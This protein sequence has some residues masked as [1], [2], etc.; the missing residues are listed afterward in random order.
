MAVAVGASRPRP[1]ARWIALAAA[2]VAAALG[3]LA[4]L[5]PVAALGAVLALLF[6]AIAF[7]DLA[8]GVAIYATVMFFET[9]PVATTAGLGAAK[10]GGLVLVL[11][12]LRRSGTPL[13][14]REHPLIAYAATFLAAWALASSLWAEDVPLAATEGSRLALNVALLFV[15]FAAVRQARHARWV[16]WGYLLGAAASALVGLVQ[17]AEGDAD[18]LAG[19]V[20]DPNFLAAMLVPAIVFAV[21]AFGWARRPAERWLLSLL[22]VVYTIALLGTQSRG[23]LVAL[24]VTL[25]AGMLLGGAFRRHFAVLTAAIAFAGLV[26]YGAFASA[27]ALERVTNPGGGAGRADLWSVAT[28]VAGDHPVVGVGAGNFPVVAPQYVTEPLDLREVQLVVDEPTVAH[29]TYIGVLAELG[30]VGLIAFAVVVLAALA[31]ARR[32]TKA[33]RRASAPELEL[34]SRAVLLGLVGMLTAFVFL[35]G[36]YENQLWL[37]LG[38]AVA[39]YTIARRRERE[40]APPSSSQ[41]DASP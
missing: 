1:D 25:V 14:L 6:V 34:L 38:L 37:L 19:S 33:F 21:F 9:L 17:P 13:L 39:L 20:G 41:A 5:S 35:S 23:G 36:L 40:D 8:L 30:V 22:L 3:A 32:A 10:V 11:A 4:V 26:Y 31:L 28:E 29:N 15:I 18:R 16:V 7:H 12:A 2:P 27:A 24:G